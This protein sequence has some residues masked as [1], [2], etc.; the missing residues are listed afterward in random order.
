MITRYSVLLCGLLA[1]AGMVAQSAAHAEEFAAQVVW[2]IDGDTVIVLRGCGHEERG[3]KAPRHS[4][5]AGSQK[6]KIRLAN[7]DAPE[8]DQDG[9]IASRKSLADMVLH[10][11]VGVSS[12]AVDQY[13]RT[14]ATLSLNGTNINEEQVRRG[15]A[16]EYSN[17][18]ADKT[19]VALERAAREATRGLWAQPGSMPPWQWRKLHRADAPAAARPACGSKRYCSQ[20]ASCDEARFYM[21][22]CGLKSLDGNGDGVPCEVLCAAQDGGAAPRLR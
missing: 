9:G 22:R 2:V 7:I 16:W 13:G 10:K 11:E 5:C 14:V 6:L 20:M 12:Q 19:Y 3:T 21:A 18:H 1:S 4:P 17:Y 15:M 8:K